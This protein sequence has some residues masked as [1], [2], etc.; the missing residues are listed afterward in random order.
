[1]RS[2]LSVQLLTRIA[3]SRKHERIAGHQLEPY[4]H[5]TYAS[6]APIVETVSQ[7]Q[8]TAILGQTLEA[9][10]LRQRF[11]PCVD[12]AIADGNIFRHEALSPI[13]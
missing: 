5:L 13:E 1:V 6:F 11:C 12:H 3:Q 10:R 7:H 4:R 2:L 8:P 9:D